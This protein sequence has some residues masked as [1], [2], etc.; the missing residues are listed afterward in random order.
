M[1]TS[2]WI[3][4][5]FKDMGLWLERESVKVDGVKEILFPQRDFV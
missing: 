5:P 4:M 1:S 3:L 2:P